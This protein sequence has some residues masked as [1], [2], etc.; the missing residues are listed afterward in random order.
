V[1]KMNHHI[2]EIEPGTIGYEQL[3]CA[4][5]NRAL[6]AWAKRRGIIWES[7]FRRSVDFGRKKKGTPSHGR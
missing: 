4:A 7:A 6:N 3:D 5:M 1:K 2:L